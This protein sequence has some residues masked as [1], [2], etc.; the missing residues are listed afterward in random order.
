MPA[1]RQALQADQRAA[2]IEPLHHLDE[3]RA[4]VADPVAAGTTTIEKD[5]AAADRLAAES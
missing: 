2:E 4:F 1:L 5:R 3:T